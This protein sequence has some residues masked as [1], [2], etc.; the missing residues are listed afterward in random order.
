MLFYLYPITMLAL[1]QLILFS[2]IMGSIYG[3]AVARQA[4]LK[5]Y[6]INQ[7]IP[8]WGFIPEAQ[9]KKTAA[10]PFLS[11]ADL[12]K[13]IKIDP[14]PNNISFKCAPDPFSEGNAGVCCVSWI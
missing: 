7:V 5:K 11:M 1:I 8:E 13:G 3:A 6:T 2:S 9:G 12:Q 14:P 4:A 10:P